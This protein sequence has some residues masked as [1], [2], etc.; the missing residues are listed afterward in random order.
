MAKT[1]I[2]ELTTSLFRVQ[3]P[4]VF[5]PYTPQKKKNDPNF[6]PKYELVMLF[7]KENEKAMAFVT[8][9]KAEA[10]R[11]AIAKW[12]ENQP[13]ERRSPFRDADKEGKTYDGYPGHV[14]IRAATKFKPKII[15][16][17]E[18]PVEMPDQVYAGCWMRA[19]VHAYWYDNESQGISIGLGNL[20]FDHDDDAFSGGGS[21]PVEDFADLTTQAAPAAPSDGENM[22]D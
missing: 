14:F 17:G 9:L 19:R 16:L 13:P 22:F 11:I 6:E 7:D 4:H 8:Q 10:Q 15:D 1:K 12:G 18:N 5:E 2:V 3:F 21:N 20:L